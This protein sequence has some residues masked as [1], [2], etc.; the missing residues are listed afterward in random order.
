MRERIVTWSNFLSLF[1]DTPIEYGSKQKS[2]DGVVCLKIRDFQVGMKNIDVEGKIIE[3][4][5]TSEVYSRYGYVHRAS[6]AKISDE[7]SSIRLILWNEQI[8]GIS[9]GDVVQ[10][11]NG[12]VSQFRGVDQ[13]NIGKRNGKITV[14]QKHLDS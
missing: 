2:D 3:K 4:S 13:L 10:I 6:Y 1:W 8:D 11:K 9:V 5:D 14:I 12:Y 7:T